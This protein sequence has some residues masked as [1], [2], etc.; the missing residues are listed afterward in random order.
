MHHSLICTLVVIF[1]NDLDLDLDLQLFQL[2]WRIFVASFV[3][4]P[5]P[6]KETL[7]RT[8]FVNW[9]TQCLH[10][11]PL[12]ITDGSKA[13]FGGNMVSAEREPMTGSGGRALSGVQGR[14]PGQGVTE[15]ERLFALNTRSRPNLSRNLFFVKQKISSESDVGA[16]CPLAGPW[17]PGCANAYD[18]R[19]YSE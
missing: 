2:T 10:H 11:A 16:H 18:G 14:A 17:P 15:A 19:R 6:N 4:I 8:N 5:P 9:L 12:M 1:G 3:E 7:R 13:K